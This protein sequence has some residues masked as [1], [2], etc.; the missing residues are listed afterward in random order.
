MIDTARPTPTASE[1]AARRPP[2][3]ATE[4]LDVAARRRR[5]D[6]RRRAAT[7]DLLGVLAW[8]SAAFA[9]ALWLMSPGSHTVVGIGGWLTDAGIVAGLIATDLVLVMLVLAARV[10]L[11]DRTFGQDNAIAVHR[12]LG[13]PVLYLLLA[14]GALLTLG[15]GASAGTGPIAQTIALFSS[16]DMPLAYLGL[17]LFVAVVVSSLVAVRSRLPYEAWHG[18]HLLSYAAVL[19]ALPHMLSAGSVLAQGTWQRVYWIALYVVAL[20]LIAVYRFAMPLVV[21]FRHRI[22][23]VGVE[24][25]A[26]GV[27]SIHLAGRDLDRLGTRGGQY[28][29]WRFWTARTWWHAHPVS[30]SAVPGRD[31][32]RITV[33][34]LGAGSARLGRI[35]PG[36]FVSLEGPYGLFTSRARTAPYLALVASGIGI[37]PVRAL[38]EDTDLR[39][40]E[41]TVLLRGSDAD[42]QYLWHETA[43][44]AAATGS[45]FFTMVGRRATSRASWMTEDDLRRG[46]SLTSVFPRL[47]DSDLYVCGPQAWSDQVVLE[48]RLAGVP[49]HQIHQERFGS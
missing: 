4:P 34:D 10:P 25:V 13:K 5:R 48:A 3:A 12:S 23:V 11:I 29:V 42:Q 2:T 6:G 49:E 24:P 41:A 18:I 30:F 47:L 15:Y 14:H 36:A 22:R 45:R 9:V 28:G 17:G 31:R 7:T 46:V 43:D 40:G 1:R 37:T 38:L 19:V 33:R 8:V 35:T 32:A 20:G 27:V 21:T 44:L 26:P 39:P 16:P